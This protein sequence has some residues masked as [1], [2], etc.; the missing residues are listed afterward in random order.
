M[1]DILPNKK[2]ASESGDDSGLA[3]VSKRKSWFLPLWASLLLGFTACVFAPLETY[4]VTIDELNF[5]ILDLLPVVFL[6]GLLVFGLCFGVHFLL[7]GKLRLVFSALCVA[8]SLAL[9]LQGNY[10]NISYGPLNGTLIRWD[11]FGSYPFWNTL[12]WA[13]LLL[14]PVLAAFFLPKR[15]RVAFQFLS[16]FVLAMEIVSLSAL[17]LTTDL[18]G[19][20]SMYYLSTKNEF[21]FSKNNN[22]VVFGIDSFAPDYFQEIRQHYPEA[23]ES[24]TGFVE[25]PHHSGKFPAT[26]WAIRNLMTGTPYE[27]QPNPKKFTEIAYENS[28]LIPTLKAHGYDVDFFVPEGI[29]QNCEKYFDNFITS[30]IHVNSHFTLL[31]KIYRLT[32][33]FYAPHV[34]KQFCWMTTADFDAIRV[35]TRDDIFLRDDADFRKRFDASGIRVEK[36]NDSFH[37]FF[38]LGPHSPFILKEPDENT[39]YYNDEVT[40]HSQTLHSLDTVTAIMNAMKEKGIYDDATIIILADHGDLVYNNAPF[41][42]VKLPGA[43]GP[44]TQNNSFVSQNDFEATIFAAAGIDATSA[45]GKNVFEVGD[46]KRTFTFYDLPFNKSVEYQ[47]DLTLLDNGELHYEQ[48]DTWYDANGSHPVKLTQIRPGQTYSL[49]TPAAAHPYFNYMDHYRFYATEGGGSVWL[50]KPGVTLHVQADE[51]LSQG[52]FVEFGLTDVMNDTQRVEVWRKNTLFQTH[53]VQKGQPTLQMEIPAE[54]RAGGEIILELR[55]P[56]AMSVYQKNGFKN[57]Y[58]NYYRQSIAVDSITFHSKTN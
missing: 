2:A 7:K 8:A 10:L 19:R 43:T 22:I 28:T 27:A 6:C 12:V 4:L 54:C 58:D 46:E 20:G 50:T 13:L 45:V 55:F 38:T 48:K 56:D 39:F 29:V 41:L 40:Q 11:T 3:P 36:E 33:F 14:L 49:S 35:K 26:N 23:F 53:T 30:P 15:A 42:L 37:F 24:W 31:K 9:Y 32:G 51:A 16:V 57:H 25:F 52:L 21:N 5:S 1:T 17:L 34:A 47:Y 44:I 18:S